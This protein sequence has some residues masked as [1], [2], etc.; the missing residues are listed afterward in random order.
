MLLNLQRTLRLTGSTLLLPPGTPK[1]SAE[2][3]REAMRKTFRNPG[4]L[5]AYRKAT[6]D[7]ATPVM[8]EELQRIVTEAPRDREV[9]ALFNKIAGPEPLPEH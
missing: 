8:P 2:V 1:E 6:G 3:L 9:I 4:F 7:D 5:A